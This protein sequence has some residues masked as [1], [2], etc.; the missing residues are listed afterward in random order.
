MKSSP[1]RWLA[2]GLAFTAA[3][4]ALGGCGSVQRNDPTAAGS[5]IEDAKGHTSA[6]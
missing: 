1:I 6:L 4:A 2:L 5:S 3:F